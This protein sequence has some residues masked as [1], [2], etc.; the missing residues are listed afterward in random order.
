[1]P[2][3]LQT[4]DSRIRE[5][6]SIVE[7]ILADGASQHLLFDKMDKIAFRLWPTLREKTRKEYVIIAIKMALS[8]PFADFDFLIEG[9][10]P[11][12]AT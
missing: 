7:A 9:V 5:L 4:R 10:P 1:M 6:A 2:S 11:R 12:E 8:K 3:P